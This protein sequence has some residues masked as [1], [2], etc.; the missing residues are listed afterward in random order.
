MN[1]QSWG[2]TPVLPRGPLTACHPV[3]PRH[4]HI[5]CYLRGPC[6]SH[7]LLAQVT[8]W[9]KFRI[10]PYPFSISQA[11][12]GPLFFLTD[13]VSHC[14]CCL[15]QIRVIHKQAWPKWL[16]K[17]LNRQ[18][19]EFFHLILVTLLLKL[20]FIFFP[21]K[22]RAQNWKQHYRSGLICA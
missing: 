22:F 13:S 17:M 20:W 5:P 21:L 10:L 6:L 7:P 4:N 16:I 12:F 3:A 2:Q 1:P 18:A 14:I 11:D 8:A 15:C 9:L 19:E